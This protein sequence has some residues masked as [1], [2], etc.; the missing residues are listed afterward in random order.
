MI[1]LFDE[2]TLKLA[3]KW[4][5][6]LLVVITVSIVVYSGVKKLKKDNEEKVFQ[7]E[8][9]KQINTSNLTLPELEYKTM[10]DM[11]YTA[12]K[13]WGTDEK[14]IYS[15]FAK[16]QNEDDYK[17]LRSAFGIRDKEN[18]EQ[19]IVGDMNEKERQ[20]INAILNVNG[21][22]AKF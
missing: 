6:I 22:S 8:I 19:W 21:I 18:L 7:N 16:L 2:K 13:G 12:M 15:V 10:A 9:E 3:G 11:L 20:Q 17:K 4:L 1:S 5:L 14:V